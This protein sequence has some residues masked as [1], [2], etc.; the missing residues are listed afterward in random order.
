MKVKSPTAAF[1]ATLI[2]GREQVAVYS[3]AGAV[4]DP[5]CLLTSDLMPWLTTGDRLHSFAGNQNPA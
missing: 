3:A 1:K 5:H 4:L 2:A